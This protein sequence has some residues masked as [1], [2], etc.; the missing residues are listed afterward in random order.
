MGKSASSP[1]ARNSTYFSPL[2][3]STNCPSARPSAR[4]IANGSTA[5]PRNSVF[6]LRSVASRLRCHTRNAPKEMSGASAKAVN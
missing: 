6:Q 4:M 2:S 5:M 1:G 3:S